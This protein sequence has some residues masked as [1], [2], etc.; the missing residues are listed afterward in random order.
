MEQRKK[1]KGEASKAN[2]VG[3]SQ[4]NTANQSVPHET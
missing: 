1:S 2:S 3:D 4:E